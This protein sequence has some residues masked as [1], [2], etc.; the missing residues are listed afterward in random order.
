MKGSILFTPKFTNVVQSIIEMGK[1]AAEVI[2]KYAGK[3]PFQKEHKCHVSLIE[4][5]ATKGW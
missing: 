3:L 4:C 2:I 5:Q 1:L